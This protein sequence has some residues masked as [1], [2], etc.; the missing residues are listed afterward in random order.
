MF[1][2]NGN[3]IPFL[4][5]HR[6]CQGVSRIIP[7]LNKQFALY[8]PPVFCWFFYLVF[9]QRNFLKKNFFY[10]ILFGFFT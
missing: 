5:P 6:K 8:F 4:M 1:D 10:F 7:P 3:P 2:L 9:E